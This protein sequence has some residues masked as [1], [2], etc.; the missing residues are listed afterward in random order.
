MLENVIL[1]V[2][3]HLRQAIRDV[4]GTDIAL[5]STYCRG[6]DLELHAPAVLEIPIAQIS[7]HLVANAKTQ[8]AGVGCLAMGPQDNPEGWRKAMRA[9]VDWIMTDFPDGLSDMLHS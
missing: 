4:G 5:I 2:A 9:G 3:H 7:P 1:C 8:G 6:D